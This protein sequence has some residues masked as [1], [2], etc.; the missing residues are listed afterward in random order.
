MNTKTLSFLAIIAVTFPG[1]SP[2]LYAGGRDYKPVIV[3]SEFTNKITNPYFPLTPGTVRKYV[4]KGG[5]EVAE[6]TSTVTGGTK[7]LMGVRCVVVHE[8][9]FIAGKQTEDKNEWYAQHKD[10]S[11]WFFGELTKEFKAGGRVSTEGSW[12]AGVGGALPGIVMPGE[13]KPGL[14]FR[15]E[16]APD[17]AEDMGEVQGLRESATTPAGKFDDCVRIREWSMLEAGS[18]KQWFARGVGFVRS[19]ATGGE[20]C[21]LVSTNRK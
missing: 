11:V 19:E 3:P 7:T 14:R 9:V 1:I 4:E 17:T 6:I 8:V 2:V 10:G 12:E 13:L 21:V 20:E 18:A 5:A 15:E 16:F